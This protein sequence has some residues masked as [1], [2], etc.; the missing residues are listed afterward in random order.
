M[1]KKS[2][3]STIITPLTGLNYFKLK[4]L[5]VACPI[6]KQSSMPA[7]YARITNKKSKTD[8]VAGMPATYTEWFIDFK[9]D[10]K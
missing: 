7:K 4:A 3:Y 10:Y 5:V 9:N 6:Q 2:F 8:I 1:K